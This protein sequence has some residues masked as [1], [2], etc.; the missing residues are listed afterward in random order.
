[1][2]IFTKLNRII[3]LRNGILSRLN[4]LGVVNNSA[5]LETCKTAL[6]NMSDNT[7][8]TTT[9]NPIK[10]SFYS[11]TSQKIYGKVGEGYCSS[12]SLVEVPVANLVSY[13]IRD[14]INVG[15]VVGTF[16]G[17]ATKGSI[18]GSNS[19]FLTIYHGLGVVPD[20]FEA[21]CFQDTGRDVKKIHYE[22]GMDSNSAAFVVTGEGS[23]LSGK[24][25]IDNNAI[26]LET[27]D[28][29]SRLRY[30]SGSTYCWM[31]AKY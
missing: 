20:M 14:G 13:Y 23:G 2:S 7:K 16:K 25:L 11:G 3:T 26:Y 31:A 6:D 10:G 1:M 5:K 4:T 21:N 22:R 8:K 9:S 12:S 15:G 29:Y 27:S 28:D 17:T 19:R 18:A 24:Y 30:F